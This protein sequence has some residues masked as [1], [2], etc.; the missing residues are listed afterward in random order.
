[1]D[2]ATQLCLGNLLMNEILK[3]VLTVKNE[4][5]IKD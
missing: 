3:D 4:Q 1:M 2:L 5:L